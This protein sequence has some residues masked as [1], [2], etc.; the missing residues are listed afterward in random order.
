MSTRI[1]VNLITL[2]EQANAAACLE[3]LGWA[4]EIVVVDGGSHD[5]TVEI[6]R[7]FTDRIAIRPF[8]DF[9]SQRNRAIDLSRGDWIFSIDAD[10]RVGEP[11]ASEIRRATSLPETEASGFWVPIRSRIFGRRFRYSG[12][13]GERKLRLFRRHAGRWRGRVH[14]VVDLSGRAGQLQNAVEHDSTPDLDAYLHKLIRYSSL[15]ADR[16]HAAGVRASGLRRALRPLWT[17]VKLYLIKRGMLDGPEGLR[18][19]ALSAWNEW[20]TNQKLAERWHA[21]HKTAAADDAAT[22]FL[23]ST[24]LVKDDAYGE[25]TA[26]A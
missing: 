3:S 10:E 19:C 18:F 20:V 26:A 17:F 24:T 23:Q 5:R 25:I 2:N 9:A 7:G 6:A 11:L 16:L 21:A 1:S 13:Q 8:D 22:R 12:T 14:E 4:D 15:E